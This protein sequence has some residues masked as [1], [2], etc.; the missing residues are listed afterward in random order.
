MPARATRGRWEHPG[1]G[2]ARTRWAAGDPRATAIAAAPPGHGSSPSL[3]I[4]PV[5]AIVVL[6]GSLGSRRERRR[7]V[8]SNDLPDPSTLGSLTFAQPTV[9]YDRT[10]KVQLGVFQQERRRVVTFDEVP[11]L[12][13]DATTT[14]ED[15][16]F[17]Q[18]V[19]FDPARSSPRSPR[20]PAASSERGASTITQQLVRARLLPPSA[21]AAGADRYIR[22]AKE[23][24]QSTRL[25]DEF[26]GEAGKE[27]IIS[28][29][30]NQIFYGH[31][32]YGIAAAAEIYFGVTD[33]S[34]LTPAQAALLAGLPKS[35]ST[36]DPYRYAQP[37]ARA[38]RRPAGR[39]ARRPPQLHPRE[40]IASAR[41]TTL[42]PTELQ[43]ALTEPVVLVGDRPLSLRA[44]H[45]TWQVR[46]QL[47]AIIGDGPLGR[48]RRLPR[49][50]DARLERP[51]P[52]RAVALRRGHRPQPQAGQRVAPAARA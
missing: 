2:L 46:R 19:G 31:D 26:P 52:G 48:D 36:L 49:H 12:V 3:L 33:L 24:I 7:R 34:Q 20:T 27:Q 37:D 13:L 35:P 44:P 43:A 45:F 11:R 6:G 1:A 42:S 17:W 4:V 14:A 25:T 29:Y 51:V 32:A 5:V 23:L 47:D 10:G 16:T 8:L 21:T 22:K 30:L 38:A 9:V 40:P 41:W 28:A 50:H 15:R 39:A 18:N